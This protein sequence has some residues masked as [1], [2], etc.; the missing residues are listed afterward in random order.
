MSTTGTPQGTAP[1]EASARQRPARRALR[2]VAHFCFGC[3]VAALVLLGGAVLVLGAGFTAPTWVREQAAERIGTALPGYDLRFGTISFRVD[4]GLAPRVALR[5]VVISESGGAP[6]ASLSGLE[7]AVAPGPLLQGEV[8]PSSVRLK[9][10]RLVVRRRP[11][12][13]LSIA[14]EGTGGGDGGRDGEIVT[15][16]DQ[17]SA[18]FARPELVALREVSAENLGLRYEDARAGR[19]WTADGGQV[20]LVREGDTIGLR[21]SVTVLGARDYASTLELSY[22]GTLGRTDAEFGVRFEDVPAGDIAGQ[23]PALAWLGALDAPISGALRAAVDGNGRLGP[24]NA[25]LQIG[26]GAVQPTPGTEPIAFRSA[27]SYFT[28]DPARAEIVFSELSVDSAWGSAQAEGRARL[29]GME[30][31]WPQELEAQI[32]V[33]EIIANPDGAYPEPVTFESAQMDLRLRPEPFTLSIGEARLNDEGRTLVLRG[34]VSGRTDGWDLAM[35]ARMDG[36]SPARL[37]ALW[38]QAFKPKVRDWIA[39]NVRQAELNDIQLAFRARPET[40]ADIALGFAFQEFES[41]FVRGMPPISAA[42]GY[43]SIH[44]NRLVMHADHG[45]VTAAQGGRIDISGTSFIIPDL[46]LR[47]SPARALLR[48]EGTITAALSLLD[49]PPFRF[50]QKAGRPVALADGTARLEGQL[51]FLLKERMTPDEVAFAATGA[52]ADVRSEVLVPGRVLAAERLDVRTDN[53]GI[54][55]SGRARV[56]AVPVS[57]T[58]AMTLGD[59]PQGESRVRGRIEL[60]E[61]FLDE[62]AIALPPGSVSGNGHADLEIGLAREQPGQFALTSDLAG[63]SLRIPQLDWTLGADQT[64]RLDVAGTLGSPPQIDSLSLEAPGLSAKGSVRLGADGAFERAEFSRITRADWMDAPVTLVARGPGLAPRVVVS[65]GTVDL[66]RASFGGEGGA[67][68][69]APVA[70]RLDRAQITESIALTD[71][72]ADLDTTGG[73]RGT[74]TGLVNGRSPVS[75]EVMP[76]AG[77]SAFR[78]RSEDAG[79]VLAAAGLLQQARNGTLEMTLTPAPEPDG[80]DGVLGIDQIRVKEAPTLAAL[81]NTVSIV[82]LLEQFYGN[83]LHFGRVDARFRLTPERL[84]LL[85]G[86]AVGASVGLSMDG[87]YDPASRQIDMQGVLSPVYVL[88]AIGGIL[89]RSGEGV[90][91]VNYTLKG[92]VSDP[93]VGINPLSAMAP[94]F[95]REMF[96]RPAPQVEGAPPAAVS[97]QSD[98]PPPQDRTGAGQRSER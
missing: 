88:N 70:V 63:L 51:D 84:T 93:E 54:E 12:G 36:L 59:N 7:V 40:G 72:Q 44:D 19:A 3:S 85:E 6:L 47:Q 83:G 31:D 66:G 17:L 30:R 62:F 94:G 13:T 90:F 26:A 79:G 60:S 22:D 58:W 9:G 41:V 98:A 38:P 56:G 50:L 82:G 2:H 53:A 49:S 97:R 35:D 68:A 65:G 91:G 27:R 57:G 75:G 1:K 24:L 45:H 21:G 74:F 73:T 25:T 29:V 64:G 77:R 95:L 67:T 48:T 71:V 87:Y 69:G 80:F 4:R 14:L 92:P 34:E 42:S 39:R 23:S 8:R 52:L 18:V 81:L 37:L 32:R 28:Y 46:R 55:I 20:S 10:G 43:A 15:L 89:T 86:S 78:I 76:M 61:R 33:S 96:R 11:D 16:A 5:D